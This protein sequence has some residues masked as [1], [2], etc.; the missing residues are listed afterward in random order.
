MISHISAAYIYPVIGAPI[1]DGVLAV[2]PKGIIKGIYT[3]QEAKEKR[4]SDI[5]YHEGLLVPGFINTH[6]H[7]ELS[8]L[9]GKIPQRT[10]LP[11][12][13]K[14]VIR[15]RTSDEYELNLAMLKADIEMYENGIVAVGDISNQLISKS[16]KANS[17]VYYFTFLEIMGFKPDVAAEAM[18]QGKAI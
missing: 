3:A 9:R 1:K 8:N 12:F 14:S 10:G 18:E 7:L 6:C 2:D 17:P 13:V 5:K 16:L 4:I 11:E 15:L